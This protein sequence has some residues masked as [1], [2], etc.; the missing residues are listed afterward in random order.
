[1]PALVVAE[2]SY[3]AR[4]RLGT[5]AE[6]RFLEDIATGV[7]GVMPVEH[8]EWGRIIELTMRYR[9]LP[10]GTVDASLVAL[11]ERLRIAQIAT[12]DVRDFGAVRPNHVESFELLPEARWEYP[13]R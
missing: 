5:E 9:D 11:A 12:L 4:T 7:L 13:S 2:V 10:L 1:V 3:F 8:D 6:V